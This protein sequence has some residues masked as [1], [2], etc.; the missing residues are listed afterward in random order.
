MSESSLMDKELFDFLKKSKKEQLFK[1]DEIKFTKDLYK[2][3]RESDHGYLKPN[4]DNQVQRDSRDSNLRPELFP[5]TSN[6]T[7]N[8]RSKS[9]TNRSP[10]SKIDKN[11]SGR[12]SHNMDQDQEVQSLI[13]SYP[14]FLK[15][16]NIEIESIENLNNKSKKDKNKIKNEN[17]K[18]IENGTK[19]LEPKLNNSKRENISKE[20]NDKEGSDS[21][22]LLKNNSQQEINQ[23]VLKDENINKNEEAITEDLKSKQAGDKYHKNDDELQVEAKDIE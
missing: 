3:D 6:P 2:N 7:F 10:I 22:F 20:E 19:E 8:S 12:D 15:K 23:V 18:L 4:Y 16:K 21:K 17:E 9:K 11:F 5:S 13:Q 14:K 1:N